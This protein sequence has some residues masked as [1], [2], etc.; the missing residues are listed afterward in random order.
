M[1]ETYQVANF[2]VLILETRNRFELLRTGHFAIQV[3]ERNALQ[4]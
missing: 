2:A 3:E 1:E 4:L